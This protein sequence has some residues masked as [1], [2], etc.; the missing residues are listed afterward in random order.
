MIETQAGT[1]FFSISRGS[2]GNT[3]TGDRGSRLQCRPW[4]S[5]S[6]RP[7]IDSRPSRL[8][9]GMFLQFARGPIGHQVGSWPHSRQGDLRANTVNTQ[10]TPGGPSP[11]FPGGCQR[12]PSCSLLALVA[13]LGPACPGQHRQSPLLGKLTSGCGSSRRNNSARLLREF[14][15]EPRATTTRK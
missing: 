11:S 2:H 7:T 14:C 8:R 12:W 13:F 9:S 10:R 5:G 15:G 6:P 1:R 3:S 4:P